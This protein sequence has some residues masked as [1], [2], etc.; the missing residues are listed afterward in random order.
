MNKVFLIE[1]QKTKTKSCIIMYYDIRTTFNTAQK[2]LVHDYNSTSNYYPVSTKNGSFIIP[3]ETYIYN[4]RF[5]MD[6]TPEMKQIVSTFDSN[7]KAIFNFP[8]PI[9]EINI[10]EVDEPT[11]EEER[12]LLEDYRRPINYYTK[13]LQE[14][15]ST[16]TDPNIITIFGKIKNRTYKNRLNNYV[17]NIK[18]ID[19]RI[20]DA[21]TKKHILEAMKQ[22]AFGKTNTELEQDL[23]TAR[24]KLQKQKENME[25]Y[26]NNPENSSQEV[27][28]ELNRRAEEILGTHIDFLSSLTASITNK[29]QSIPTLQASVGITKKDKVAL[30]KRYAYLSTMKSSISSIYAYST[31]GTSIDQIENDAN[32][33]WKTEQIQRLRKI[34]IDENE[35]KMGYK[36]PDGW[37]EQLWNPADGIKFGFEKLVG[38]STITEKSTKYTAKDKVVELI[39]QC[40]YFTS[41]QVPTLKE[42]GGKLYNV[43][44]ETN[45]YEF[46]KILF[47][48]PTKTLDEMVS[49]YLTPGRPNA[50]C[51]T[52]ETL[53]RLF[54]FLGG[55]KSI[56][57]QKG[58]E[59]RFIEKIELKGI[60]IREN[61]LCKN[62]VRLFPQDNNTQQFFLH[63]QHIS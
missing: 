14:R 45:M 63:K 31:I 16:I 30:G 7:P 20:T 8:I 40:N 48:D 61:K 39:E 58:G 13:N 43:N 51:D 47:L 46:I 35:I 24:E 42:P 25:P 6:L 17:E 57:P 21:A 53:A 19:E 2:K 9:Q 49:F 22:S 34:T 52:Y 23:R 59:Y 29:M 41:S 50:G 26:M 60:K 32:N 44:R 55:I 5:M 11:N 12:Q 54:V 10:V 3:I 36:R 37:E 4:R 56:N 38:V 28:N 33:A 1:P 15:Y 62:C 18:I 27:S